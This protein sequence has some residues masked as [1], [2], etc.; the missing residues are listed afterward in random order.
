MAAISAFCTGISGSTKPVC[1]QAS[2][3]ASLIGPELIQISGS[4][5]LIEIDATQQ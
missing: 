4:L 1:D 3:I 2:F 5:Q